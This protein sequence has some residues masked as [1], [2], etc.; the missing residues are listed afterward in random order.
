MMKKA[1]FKERIIIL[2]EIFFIT[3]HHVKILIY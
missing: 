1:L 3:M 2:I